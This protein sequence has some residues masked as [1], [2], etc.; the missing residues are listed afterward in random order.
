MIQNADTNKSVKIR[1]SDYFLIRFCQKSRFLLRR[2][3]DW[4]TRLLQS[5]LET[6]RLESPVFITGL[7]RSGT[8]LLLELLA[9]VSG[10]ATHRYRDFPFLMIPYFW[11]QYLDRFPV[12]E[13][14]VE[15]AHKDRI[16]VTRENPEAME[17]PLWQAFFPQVH[18]TSNL[19]RLTPGDSNLDFE[20][21]YTTHLRKMLLVRGGTRYLAKANYH[22]ARLEYLDHLFPD[23]RFIVPVRHPLTHVHSL[24][25]QHELFT[26]Y[27]ADDPRVARYLEA[28]GHFEFGPQRVPIR[29]SVEQGDRVMKAWSRGEEYLGY[30]IQ[31]R[32][33]Y[34]F[35]NTIRTT[36]PE[37]ARRL[38]VV[39]Y[40]DLC[41]DPRTT[42]RQILNHINVKEQDAEGVLS[43]LERISKSTHVPDLN[44]GLHGAVC[45][46]T[47]DV[48]EAY[49]YSLC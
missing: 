24:V 39:R 11:N 4:E 2:I 29:Y 31:W 5:E 16:Y 15:R 6:I 9:S 41:E 22:V 23:S 8:T 49:G 34:D 48:A 28:A 17:E 35:I 20:Q 7:A 25:R 46:E 19:H 3:A 10:F 38:L 37:I 40:E 21:F 12:N 18:S 45:E 30:A 42:M 14:P 43:Q 1:S 47:G 27:A 32:A 13:L 44:D 33:V 26:R 36:D